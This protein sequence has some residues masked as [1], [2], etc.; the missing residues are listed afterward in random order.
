MK[1]KVTHKVR[2]RMVDVRTLQR[3][4]KTHA[5]GIIEHL[6]EECGDLF[7]PLGYDGKDRKLIVNRSE[8]A[9]VRTI[10]KRFAKTGSAYA[11]VRA[12]EAECITG[13]RGKPIDEGHLFRLLNN[14][15]YVGEAAH[16]SVAYPGKHE[17]IV[18]R[19]LWDKVQQ[20]LSCAAPGLASNTQ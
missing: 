7:V 5:D 9:T 12:L 11:L 20:R 16:R 18:G 4:Y 2:R 17:A 19:A 3:I 10:F 6:V 13:K 8:A 15:I 1:H 14:P